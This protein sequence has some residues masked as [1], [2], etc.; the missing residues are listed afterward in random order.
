MTAPVVVTPVLESSPSSALRAPSPVSGEGTDDEGGALSALD[1]FRR[2]VEQLRHDN[3]RLGK[4]FSH[5]RFVALDGS[6]LKVAFPA[7]A[8]FHRATV[9][10]S[11]REAIEAVLSKSF[12]RAMKV[13]EDTSVSSLSNAPKSV[14]ENEASARAARE[15]RIEQSVRS[16]P[17]V[18][19]VMKILGGQ[20]EL[21]H[22]LEPEAPADEAERDEPVALDEPD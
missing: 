16:H 4:S 21:V 11:G 1:Q 2:A 8:G 10:G 6:Q 14:A 22:V 12:G 20:L 19:N 3:P 18:V 13:S 17:S 15:Q 9:F 5:A 7:D